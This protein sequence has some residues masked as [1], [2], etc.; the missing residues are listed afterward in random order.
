MGVE[1]DGVQVVEALR[2]TRRPGDGAR[3]AA[4]ELGEQIVYVTLRG[5]DRTIGTQRD[6]VG[7]GGWGRAGG[8]LASARV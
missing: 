2:D 4:A 1:G 6:R 8:R 5:D 7:V 3:M